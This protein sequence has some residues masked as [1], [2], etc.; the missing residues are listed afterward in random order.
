MLPNSRGNVT[1]LVQST[2][3]QDMTDKRGGKKKYGR[4]PSHKLFPTSFVEGECRH[5]QVLTLETKRA[6]G[7]RTGVA[8]AA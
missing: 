8:V 4:A 6:I 7:G 1:R 3:K 2:R 5:N